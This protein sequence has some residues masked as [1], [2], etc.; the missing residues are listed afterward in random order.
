MEDIINRAVEEVMYGRAEP[1]E[2]LAAAAEE[3]RKVV[4]RFE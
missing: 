4:K 1:R 3:M 2:A